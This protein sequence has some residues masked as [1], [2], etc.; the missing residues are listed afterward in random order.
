MISNI[1]A[2][3]TVYDLNKPELLEVNFFDVGQGDAIFVET[4]GFRQI[5]IDGGPDSTILEKLSREMPFWDRTI[6]LIILTHPDPDHLNGLIQVL[7]SYKVNL[8]GFNGAKGDNPSFSEWQKLITENKIP[9]TVLSKGKRIWL[10]KEIFLDVLSP[11]ESFEGREIKDFNSSSIVARL[12]YN[13]NEY[14]FTGDA[15]KSIEKELIE[16][17]VNLE[18]DVLKVAHHGSKTSTTE[19]F[20]EKV[21]PEIA[22]IS[23]GENNRY[24]HPHQEVLETLAKYGIRTLRT[25][26]DNDIKIISDGTNYAISTL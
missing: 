22:V 26:L 14:F 21:K 12:V 8:V 23:V 13:E 4:P 17:G 10:T 5:L 6:D 24:Q 3:T 2:W 25:D 11:K 7:K 1:L 19:E 18:S 15:P 16:S 9:L 20:L